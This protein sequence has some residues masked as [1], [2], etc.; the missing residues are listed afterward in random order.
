[1]QRLC[2]RPLFCIILQAI[3]AAVSRPLQQVNICQ[4]VCSQLLA[5]VIKANV[6]SEFMSLSVFLHN[7]NESVLTTA[8]SWIHCIYDDCFQIFVFAVTIHSRESV[9]LIKG[10]CQ[11][12]KISCPVKR[13]R[14]SIRALQLGWLIN[15]LH[16]KWLRPCLYLIVVNRTKLKPQLKIGWY[17]LQRIIS[18]LHMQLI[19]HP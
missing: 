14:S 3:K 2:T 10:W 7:R 1:M 19:F 6:Q 8:D 11:G 16:D 15:Q 13:W 4:S 18:T 12:Y 5:Q 9:Y 17:Y